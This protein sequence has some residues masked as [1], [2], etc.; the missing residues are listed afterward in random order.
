MCTYLQR[1]LF[2][3]SQ[4]PFDFFILFCHFVFWII[5]SQIWSTT[6]LYKKSS[7]WFLLI[8]LRLLAPDIKTNLNKETIYT[9]YYKFFGFLILFGLKKIGFRNPLCS[10]ISTCV[11][12]ITI[13]FISFVSLYSLVLFTSFLRFLYNLGVR[14]FLVQFFFLQKPKKYYNF[15]LFLNASRNRIIRRYLGLSL[16]AKSRTVENIFYEKWPYRKNRN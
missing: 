14:D 9:F 16:V 15:N 7:S 10:F 1:D 8:I 5:L 3:P 6:R 2:L 13:L 12:Y 4:L 11:F